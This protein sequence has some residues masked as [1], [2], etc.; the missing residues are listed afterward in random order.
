MCGRF[1]LAAS[2][3]AL[4]RFI[5]LVAGFPEVFQTSDVEAWRP[6]YNLAPTQDALCLRS[7]GGAPIS[8]EGEPV[9]QAPFE[10]KRLRWGL[11]PPWKP[12]GPPVINARKETLAQRSL[13]RKALQERRC[14]VLADGFYEW[15]R[16]GQ[17][18]SAFLFRRRDR[19]VFAFAGLWQPI[20]G[21]TGACAIV[22]TA[23]TD[24]LAP[25][26]DRMPVI[27]DESALSDWIKVRTTETEEL[28]GLL[29]PIPTDQMEAVPVADRVNDVHHDDPSC[30]NLRGQRA[31]F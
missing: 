2:P 23:A 10:V 8:V 29:T 22:T 7:P 25:I 13:F 3:D 4:L 14:L 30:Q 31:L 20:A 24:L 1:A 19:A 17:Q 18:R 16:E 5:A 6:R 27:L 9:S 12:D 15:K 28:L 11:A 21:S 26:H